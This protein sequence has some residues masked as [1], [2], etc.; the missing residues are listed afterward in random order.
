MK[1]S[2]ITIIFFLIYTLFISLDAF[3]HK[4]LIDTLVNKDGTVL[5]EAFFPDGSPAKNT[6]I[7]VFSPAGSLFTKGTTNESGQFIVTPEEKPGTWKAVAEGK[8]GHKT[9]TEFEIGAGV[10]EKE[11][12]KLAEKE[13][14][15]R[16]KRKKLTHKEPIPWYNIISGLGFIFG[17]SAFIISLKLRAELKKVML[18]LKNST[19]KPEE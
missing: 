11:P 10:G 15:S 7:E 19:S 14:E 8:M 16:P 13:E 6:K 3:A 1:L 4:M 5:I 9:S 17:V 12:V 18:L 2:K